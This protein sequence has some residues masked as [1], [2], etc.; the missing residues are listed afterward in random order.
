MRESDV[1]LDFVIG[2]SYI[3][4]VAIIIAHLSSIFTIDNLSIISLCCFDTWRLWWCVT[5]IYLGQPNI[6]LCEVPKQDSL[7]HLE[8]RLDFE[9]SYSVESVTHQ[10]TS[11]DA[12][13]KLFGDDRNGISFVFNLSSNGLAS[14]VSAMTV[15]VDDVNATALIDNATVNCDDEAYPKILHVHTGINYTIGISFTVKIVTFIYW[16]CSIFSIELDPRLNEDQLESNRYDWFL[17]R[18]CL[19]ISWEWI[20]LYYLQYLY[21]ASIS[22]Q[23]RLQCRCDGQ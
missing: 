22:V 15:T 21:P 17:H 9:D 14:L 2:K 12:E 16:R 8:W 23:P 18:H 10:Y 11:A 13:G 1:F 7:G 19:F 20:H 3:S 5:Y 4:S 6:L